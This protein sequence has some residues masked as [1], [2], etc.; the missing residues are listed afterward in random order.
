VSKLTHLNAAGEAQMVDVTDK[1]ITERV[2][3]AEA[4]V[5][6]KQETLQMI[7]EGGHKKAM[8]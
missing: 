6:M 5:V 3:T 4:T 1:A 2:A 8:Y 7:I